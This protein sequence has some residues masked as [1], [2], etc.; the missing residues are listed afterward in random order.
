MP[1]R[2]LPGPNYAWAFAVAASF[3][4]PSQASG[5]ERSAAGPSPDSSAVELS[6]PA[7]WVYSRA[8][9]ADSAVVFSHGTHVAR[10][11]SRCTGCHPKPFRILAPTLRISHREMNAG[12]S[13]GICHDDKQAFGVR[14]R[15][16]CASCH[17][18]MP[19]A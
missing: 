6:L 9:G 13:C 8:V 5:I 11:G 1:R 15:E 19:A 4:V 17:S 10:T 3:F 18:G 16:S 12:G 2:G 7:D 14:D